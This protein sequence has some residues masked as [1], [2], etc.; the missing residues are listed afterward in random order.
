MNSVVEL[1]QRPDEPG[2]HGRMAD[3]PEARQ[4]HCGNGD[5]ERPA[6]VPARRKRADENQR[7]T[8]A[9]NPDLAEGGLEGDGAQNLG[10]DDVAPVLAHLSR[11]ER[12]PGEG[13]DGGDDNRRGRHPP[14]RPGY[15]AR[16]PDG[17][18]QPHEG[19][20][21]EQQHR[22]AEMQQAAEDERCLHESA[23]ARP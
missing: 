15:F 2:L 7:K 18:Q 21:A 13:G 16:Q 6:I 17:S 8:H 12:K 14:R 3:K 19:A 11:F 4:Q 1:M 9:P 23:R 10:I 20:G 22:R 5:D